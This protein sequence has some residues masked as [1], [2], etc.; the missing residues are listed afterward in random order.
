MKVSCNLLLLSIIMMLLGLLT[1]NKQ[2]QKLFRKDKKGMLSTI[3]MYPVP[4]S[5]I[6][7]LVKW[8]NKFY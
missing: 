3:Y 1:A 5:L 6:H 8:L 2:S 7:N 4:I